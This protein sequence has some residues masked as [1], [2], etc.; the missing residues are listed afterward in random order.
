MR[1]GVEGYEIGMIEH[2]IKG[3]MDEQLFSVLMASQHILFVI[4]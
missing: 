3:D 4:H 1:G 2:S